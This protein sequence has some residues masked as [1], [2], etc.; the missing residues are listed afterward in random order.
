MGT[1][2]AKLRRAMEEGDWG[3]A[4]RGAAKFPRLGQHK[5]AI[6]RGASVL[7]RPDFYRQ[8]G[9][10]PEVLVDAAKVALCERF[11]LPYDAAANSRACWHLAIAEKRKRYLAE[12]PEEATD[13]EH[14]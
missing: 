5:E 7:L 11:P 14:E 2:L 13:P 3:R 12:H 6:T 1:K 10:D 8:L 9:Q 4:I